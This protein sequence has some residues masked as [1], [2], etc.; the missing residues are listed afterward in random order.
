MVSS[1]TRQFG[2]SLVPAWIASGL[3]VCT[4]DLVPWA[5]ILFITHQRHY[6]ASHWQPA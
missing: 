1:D 3:L 2:G 4:A 6:G 5:A